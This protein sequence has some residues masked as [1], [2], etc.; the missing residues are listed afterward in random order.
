MKCINDDQLNICVQAG[1]NANVLGDRLLLSSYL[2]SIICN[3]F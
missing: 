2:V 1:G 3:G